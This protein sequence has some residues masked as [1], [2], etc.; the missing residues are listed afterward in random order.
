MPPLRSPANFGVKVT[1]AVQ[2][3]PEVKLAPTVQVPPG[4]SAKSRSG[5]PCVIAPTLPIVV[6]SANVS[7]TA[8]TALV[9][10]IGKVPNP[11]VTGLGG[12]GGA[13]TV[14]QSVPDAGR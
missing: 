11:G 13:V 6:F 7:V 4:I 10:P 9:C 2:V 14:T 5:A 8:V 1:S 12:V 3:C